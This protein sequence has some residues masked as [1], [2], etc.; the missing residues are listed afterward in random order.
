MSKAPGYQKNPRHRI[1]TTLVEA[2]VR[3]LLH[4]QVVAESTDVVRLEEEGHP[5]RYYFPRTGVRV[6]QLERSQSVTRCPFKGT[7]SYFTLNVGGTRLADSIWS[8]EDPYEEHLILRERLAFYT[9]KFPEL[10]IEVGD[11]QR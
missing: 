1:A 10:T 4:G 11:A 7:A 2:P 6:D 9:E 8:Y 5:V 3:V